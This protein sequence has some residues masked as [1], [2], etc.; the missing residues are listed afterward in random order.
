VSRCSEVEAVIIKFSDDEM[1]NCEI[2]KKF[3]FSASGECIV[4]P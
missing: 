1:R 3:H 2:Y 4:C